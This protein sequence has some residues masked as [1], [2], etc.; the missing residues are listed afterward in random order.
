MDS[1]LVDALVNMGAAGAV[2]GVVII[3]ARYANII[4]DKFNAQVGALSNSQ[5]E[6]VKLYLEHLDKIEQRHIE[7]ERIARA[8]ISDQ[9]SQI[10]LMLNRSLEVHQSLGKSIASLDQATRE[11]AL[12]TAAALEQSRKTRLDQTGL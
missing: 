2:I 4:A 7:E 6:R 8:Q 1:T 11:H 9:F 5:D 10:Q 3:F 12:M